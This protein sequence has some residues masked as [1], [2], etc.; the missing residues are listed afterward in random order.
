[1]TKSKKFNKL[2]KIVYYKGDSAG[3]TKKKIL[4]EKNFFCWG[5]KKCG[6]FCWG[7]KNLDFAYIF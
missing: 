7:C 6:F 2:K 5:N 4:N 3:F 1:M